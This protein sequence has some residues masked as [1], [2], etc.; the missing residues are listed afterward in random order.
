MR[1][2]GAVCEGGLI[3]AGVRRLRGGWAAVEGEMG[4]EASDSLRG[5]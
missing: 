4:V 3:H 2:T 5:N 1:L